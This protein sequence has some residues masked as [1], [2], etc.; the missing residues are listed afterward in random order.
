MIIYNNINNNKIKN[1]SKKTSKVL[2]R[3]R[4]EGERG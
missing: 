1:E 3:R 2:K 4:R